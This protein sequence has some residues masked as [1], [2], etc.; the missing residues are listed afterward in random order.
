MKQ[1]VAIT[2]IKKKHRGEG[3]LRTWGLGWGE[4]C[5]DISYDSYSYQ[6]SQNEKTVGRIHHEK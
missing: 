4:I 1:N 6:D 2:G 5:K 3:A